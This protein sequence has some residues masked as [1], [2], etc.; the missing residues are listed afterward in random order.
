MVAPYAQATQQGNKC[1]HGL[2]P[3]TC[4][5][6]S[7]MGGG[8]MRKDKDTP[9]RPGE[10]TYNECMAAWNKIQA[11]KEAKIQQRIDRLEALAHKDN[12]KFQQNIEK[13]QKSFEKALQNIQNMPAI[14]QM[15]VK[16]VINN[17]IMPVLN[18]AAKIPQAINN[19]QQ[20]FT[21]AFNVAVMVADKVVAVL[22]EIKNF[23]NAQIIEKTKKAIKTILSLF[24]QS[25]EESKEN[26]EVEKLKSREIKNILKSLFRIKTKNEE[27]IEENEH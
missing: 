6:C 11:A 24:T 18:F 8:S 5:I 9:R 26:E 12:L 3:G 13:I 19:I 17:I 25:Q 2:P 1:P 14:I 10:M 4:P 21:N 22:G 16:F 7:G 27:E 23:I 20:F 15:P